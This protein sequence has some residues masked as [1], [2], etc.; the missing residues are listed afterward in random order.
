MEG[1]NS[2]KP[3]HGDNPEEFSFDPSAR[4]QLEITTQVVDNALDALWPKGESSERSLRGKRLDAVDALESHVNQYLTGR[5]NI[6]VVQ[7]RFTILAE[8]QAQVVAA[9]IQALSDV[10]IYAIIDERNEAFG[11]VDYPQQS[12]EAEDPRAQLMIDILHTRAELFD[13]FTMLAQT[14]GS[15]DDVVSRWIDDLGEGVSAT[16]TMNDVAP[17]RFVERHLPNLIVAIKQTDD[18]IKAMPWKH[19]QWRVVKTKNNDLRRLLAQIT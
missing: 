6:I 1:N 9:R 3:E 10:D 13:E 18:V 12:D 5:G 14:M 11:T 15:H 19:D 7:D 4:E 16:I 17:L 2:H 8:L